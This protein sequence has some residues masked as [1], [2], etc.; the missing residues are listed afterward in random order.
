M[1]L[2]IAHVHI[3]SRNLAE[4]ITRSRVAD[5]SIHTPEIETDDL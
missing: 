4:M 2:G 1:Y 5:G 3:V